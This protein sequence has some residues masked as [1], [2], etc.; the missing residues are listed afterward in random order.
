MHIAIWHNLP[1]GGGKRALFDQVRSLAA[2]GHR[3]R[4]RGA[5][6]RVIN[7][8]RIAGL[9]DRGEEAEPIGRWG[10]ADSGRLFA[11]YHRFRFLEAVGAAA[12][13]GS[14]PPSLP[15]TQPG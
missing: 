14:R 11:L 9:V 10:P 15:P 12:L 13:Q 5:A 3:V 2:R 4:W 8:S 6:H 7:R 1:G